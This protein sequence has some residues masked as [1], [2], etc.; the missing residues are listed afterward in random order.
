M[1]GHDIE[2][3]VTHGSTESAGKL[4][5]SVKMPNDRPR[6]LCT[7]PGSLDVTS[8]AGWSTTGFPYL[9]ASSN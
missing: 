6:L 4:V 9:S 5:G 8:S 3:V 1:N 2:T 7:K